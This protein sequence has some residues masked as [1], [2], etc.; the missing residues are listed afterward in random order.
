MNFSKKIVNGYAYF[1]SALLVCFPLFASEDPLLW[2]NSADYTFQWWRNGA[3]INKDGK[4]DL[5]DYANI[6]AAWR[7][8][9]IE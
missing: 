7:E 6:C 9:I 1:I 5:K 3:D 4:V 8:N 2:E